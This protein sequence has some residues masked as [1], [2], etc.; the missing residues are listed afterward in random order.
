MNVASNSSSNSSKIELVH[1]AKLQR[2]IH[3]MK[4]TD[5]FVSYVWESAS[6]TPTMI[7]DHVEVSKTTRGSGLGARF[8]VQVLEHLQD[9]ETD[10]KI[11]CSFLLRVARTRPIWRE[12]FNT[13]E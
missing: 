1:D 7:L 11:T 6:A 2:F 13:G 10:I 4:P 3:H 8:A 12:K 9:S 5:A